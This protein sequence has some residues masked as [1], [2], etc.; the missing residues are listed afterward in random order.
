MLRKTL[1]TLALWGALHA[2]WAPGT[3]QAQ[4]LFGSRFGFGFADECACGIAP[5]PVTAFNCAPQ[6][7]QVPVTEMRE[8]RQTVQRPVVETKYVEQPVTEYRPVVENKTAMIPTVSYQTVTEYQTRQRDCGRWVT[9]Y[10]CRP[11][12]SP[13][14]YDSRPGLLGWLNRRTYEAR[15][16]F[17]PKMIAERTYVPN[18]ITETVPVTRQV[19]VPG[20]REV[21]YQVTRM[22]PYTTTRKV[23]VNTVRMVAEEVVTRQPVT[24]MKTVP[25][26][27]STLAFGPVWGGT[28]TA[29]IPS[30]DPLS[31]A[32]RPD[33]AFASPI[34]RREADNRP[35]RPRP[36]SDRDESFDRSRSA[37]EKGLVDPP[38]AGTPARRSSLTDPSAD[39][40]E[41]PFAPP[42]SSSR[43]SFEGPSA[44]AEAPASPSA[45][46]VGQ[47]VARRR[48]ADEAPARTTPVSVAGTLRKVDLD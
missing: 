36:L 5:P 34:P 12:V 15:M 24:V 29:V 11:T 16:A 25:Y 43:N 10:R 2:C 39:H 40:I 13:C 20:T 6:F 23:A 26:G 46:R 8:C 41:Q 1:G 27:A 45:V 28:T 48:P 17:T 37:R 7:T 44:S 9:N 38:P 32:I 4:G 3:V 19:A 31:T 35:G 42:R 22:V 30:P 33:D 18:V 21:A 47:W 14:E